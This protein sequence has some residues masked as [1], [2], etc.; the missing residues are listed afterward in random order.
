[1]RFN[2]RTHD[3]KPHPQSVRFSREEMVEDSIAC[4][5]GNANSIIAHARAN[6]VVPIPLCG[7]HNFAAAR[8]SV[9]HGI[10][11]IDHEI[12]Q[13]LLQLNRIGFNRRQIWVQQSLQL[14]GV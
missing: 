9:A 7:D 6:C 8:R 5:F 2:D 11:G 4:F 12:D 1:M 3:P 10:K 14:A 13:H